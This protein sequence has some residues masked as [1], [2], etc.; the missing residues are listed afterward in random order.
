MNKLPDKDKEYLYNVE[1]VKDLLTMVMSRAIKASPFMIDCNYFL[2]Y[3]EVH[4]MDSV[5]ICGELQDYL[6]A[7]HLNKYMDADYVHRTDMYDS[8][9]IITLRFK[10]EYVN[11]I[12]EIITMY[13]LAEG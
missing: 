5:S 2:A 13:K 7:K 1:L 11:E 6:D 10:K 3:L 12:K 4:Y 8:S 9:A